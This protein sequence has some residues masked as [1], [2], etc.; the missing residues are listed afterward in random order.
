[1]AEQ[2]KPFFPLKHETISLQITF[3]T[4]FFNKNQYFLIIRR[5]FNSESD[6]K[7]RHKIDMK[8]FTRLLCIARA[9]R[10]NKQSLEKLWGTDGDGIE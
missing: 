9:L 4:T 1:L 2:G 6:A 3:L 7:L 8:A 5:N 10:S